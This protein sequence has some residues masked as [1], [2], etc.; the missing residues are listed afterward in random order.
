MIKKISLSHEMLSKLLNFNDNNIFIAYTETKEKSVEI[1][2]V[3]PLNKLDLSNL[4][5]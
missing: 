3:D 1:V 4:N 2:I 5:K